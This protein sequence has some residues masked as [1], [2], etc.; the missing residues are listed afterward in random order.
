M[1]G[2]KKELIIS[3]LMVVAGILALGF[4]IISAVR[5]YCLY[6]FMYVL[7]YDIIICLIGICSARIIDMIISNLKNGNDE[8]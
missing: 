4:L 2:T 1:K 7:K 8:R 6:G 5:D 3:I